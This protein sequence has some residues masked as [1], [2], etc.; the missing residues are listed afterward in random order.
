M[1]CS[2]CWTSCEGPAEAGHHGR[3]VRY[4]RATGSTC[5][6]EHLIELHEHVVA[7]G[8]LD[9][10][11]VAA[12][13]RL[14]RRRRAQAAHHRAA[15]V[16]VRP[17]LGH[18]RRILDR[19]LDAMHVGGEL[20]APRR[21]CVGADPLQEQHQHRPVA[22]LT[23]LD[24]M[25]IRGRLDQ[26]RVEHLHVPGRRLLRSSVRA[27]SRRAPI[28][29]SRTAAAGSGLAS[30]FGITRRARSRHRPLFDD[31][32]PDR[33]DSDPSDDSDHAN[34][35]TDCPNVHDSSR[36]VQTIIAESSPAAQTS[37]QGKAID[38]DCMAPFAAAGTLAPLSAA[39][40]TGRASTCGLR[41]RLT[42]T[43][44][45]HPTGRGEARRD[46]ASRARAAG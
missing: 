29:G 46:P 20:A 28:G 6:A 33:H 9:V 38:A 44:A 23:G 11:V 15:E 31:R 18:A 24:E 16:V 35:S 22:E 39:A 30:Y 7:R 19:H 2:I 5:V 26:R 12:G 21:Q 40:A 1:R 45:P 14:R 4:F 42:P 27:T 17:A 10:T 13:L 41:E 37:L 36:T 43:A 3:S 25:P 32:T 34:H 8:V